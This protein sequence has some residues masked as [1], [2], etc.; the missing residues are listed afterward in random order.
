LDRADE[1]FV[2]FQAYK[3]SPFLERSLLA[4]LLYFVFESIRIRNQECFSQ[5]FDSFEHSIKRDPEFEKLL[6]KVGNSY[7]GINYS[8]G[9]NIMSMVESLFK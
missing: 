7:L 3:T 1:A 4:K 6:K 9:F 2:V 8:S 5:I